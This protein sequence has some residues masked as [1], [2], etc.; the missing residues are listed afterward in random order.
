MPAYL[1]L[2]DLEDIAIHLCDVARMAS[3]EL[4]PCELAQEVRQV[5]DKVW[6][7]ARRR[8]KETSV[9]TDECGK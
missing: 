4:G 2:D 3:N 7:E 8:A 5:A 6:A 1:N 9:V